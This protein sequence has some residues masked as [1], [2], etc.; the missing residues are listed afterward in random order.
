VLF[1]DDFEDQPAG[2]TTPT[3]WTRSGGSSGDWM[4]ATDGT[5]V[6]RQNGATSSTLRTEHATGA[7]GAPWTGAASA[8]ARVKMIA[9][10]TSGTPMAMVCVRYVDSGNYYCA[11]LVPTGVQ[12]R[13]VVGGSAAQSAVFPSNV[14]IGTWY[15]LKVSVDAAGMLTAYLGSTMMGT[16]DPGNIAS[17]FGAVGTISMEASFDN[18]VVTR[19]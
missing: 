11:G 17:G 9:A 2:S 14:A 7:S 16:Y 18:F 3:D 4:I 5:Q 19:P 6:L 13:A 15:D 1:S 12:I 10:G 8:A